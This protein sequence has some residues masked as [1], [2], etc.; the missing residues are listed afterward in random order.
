MCQVCD[1]TFTLS[2]KAR[3]QLNKSLDVDD[4]VARALQ[5]LFDDGKIDKKTFEHLFKTHNG[6]LQK[7]VEEGYGKTLAKIEYNSPNYEFLKQLQTN[8]AVFAMFKNHASV[9]D[10]AALLKDADG[11]VRSK[12]DFVKEAKKIDEDYRTRY[13]DVE[14]DTAVRQARMASQWQKIQKNKKLYPNL[15][16]LLSKA[17]KPDQKHLQYVG[18]IAPVDSAF[19]NTHYPPNRHRCQCGVEQTDEPT[20]DIPSDLP[21]VPADFA[22]N[23]GKLGQIFDVK[24]SGYYESATPKEAM[25]LIKQA[26]NAYFKEA[27]MQEPYHTFYQSKA[28]GKLYV[29]PLSYAEN[30]FEAL[31]RNGRALA[32][33]GMEFDIL[34]ALTDKELRKKILPKPLWDVERTPDFYNKKTGDLFD[35]KVM[36]GA[37]KNTISHQ[38]KEVRG[39]AENLIIEASEKWPF[40]K[41]ETID[42]ITKQMTYK[43]NKGLK[44]IWL[45]YKGDFIFN[46]HKN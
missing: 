6:P 22:F 37:T 11:N 21:A 32:N 5:Q 4:V 15:K 34:P 36:E 43:H 45:N 28:D 31:V 18:I 20:T 10:M 13:L 16:Y 23:S 35:V 1:N 24:N 12:A 19:W 29:H 8:T 17:A 2:A 46:P 39:Q 41:Q 30:D 14:Y 26:K 7:A 38:F 25:L 33:K 3:V 40:T 27:A 42:L 9:K 44:E